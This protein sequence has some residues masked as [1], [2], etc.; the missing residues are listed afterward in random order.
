MV[1]ALAAAEDGAVA[2]ALSGFAAG[3]CFFI[4]GAS[5]LIRLLQK[6]DQ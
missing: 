5:H 6:G 4:I 2:A 1:I 3:E